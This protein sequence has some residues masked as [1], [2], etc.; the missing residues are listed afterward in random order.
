MFFWKSFA[1]SALL[2]CVLLIFLMAA[3]A[4]NA[5]PPPVSLHLSPVPTIRPGA[6]GCH[7]PSPT[8][9]SNLGFLEARGTT[10]AMDLWSLFLGGIPAVNEEDQIIW[11]LGNSFNDP[12]HI[13]AIG[14]NGQHIEP[15]D[16][17]QHAESDWDR[18]GAEWGTFFK[19]PVAGCW[20][21]HV[22]GG[23]TAGDVWVIVS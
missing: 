5:P 9:T 7:P 21:F 15:L 8:D 3:C 11:R 17:K 16:L 18:L 20:D 23:S 13:I 10:P 12:V 14:P 4:S 6:P 1:W 22:T 2:S 19:L